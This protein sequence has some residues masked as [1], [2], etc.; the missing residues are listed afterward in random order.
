MKAIR[1]QEFGG[2]DKVHVENI[3]KPNVTKDHALIRVRAASVNPVD[4]MIREKE[5]NPTGADRVPMTLGQ[6]FAGVIEQIGPGSSTSF[7]EGDE[8]FGEVW[9]AFAE[10]VVVPLK[11]LARKPRGIDFVTA[12]AIPMA[13]LTAWQAVNGTAKAKSGMRLLI[14]GVSGGVGSFAAQFAKLK[15]CTVFGTASPA[16][17]DYLKSIGIER[18][19]DYH[20]TRFEDVVQDVD[21]VIDPLGG[22]TQARSWSVLKRGGLLINLVGQVD[23]EA[24]EKAGVRGVVFSMEYDVK[25]MEQIA[26]LVAQGKVKPHITKVLPLDEA[27]EALDLNQA[28]ES[29][30]ELVLEVK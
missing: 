22:E 24:A 3:V 26:D 19:V 5:F 1:I 16:S 9:G 7:R 30:G 25:Q 8:V 28:G 4:W 29:H 23:R 14:H 10:Y 13:G 11:D 15:G 6:D 2:P 20:T 21:V 17:F 12:A 18:V 27:R